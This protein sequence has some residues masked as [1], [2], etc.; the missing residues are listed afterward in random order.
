MNTEKRQTETYVLR[1]LDRLDPVTA[2]VT[3]YEPGIGKIVVECYGSAWTASWCGMG[4][5][6]LQEFFLACNNDYILG[7]MLVAMQAKDMAECFGSDWYMDLP[8]CNTSEYEYLGRIL[9]AVK[10][11]FADELQQAA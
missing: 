11:A 9:N 3:N 5:S 8:R 6:S 4:D 7:K 10:A 1:N 2:Y